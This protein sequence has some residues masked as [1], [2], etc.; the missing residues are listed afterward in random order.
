MA[1]NGK[2]WLEILILILLSPVLLLVTLIWLIFLIISYPFISLYE[3]WLKYQFWRRHGKFGRFVLFVYSDSPNW[4]DYIEANI[5]PCIKEH[6]VTLNW[7]KRR[8]WEQTNPF[9]AK[10]FY[11]WAGEEEFNPMA[12]I[13]PLSGKVKEV[14]FW[15]AFRDFKHGKDK[16]LKAAE[17]ILFGEVERC[18][19]SDVP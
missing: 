5:L 4:K 3:Q 7:S 15:Q 19:A 10:I 18:R 2:D 14:R 12:I 11:H 16:A 8:E 6:V 1:K 13:L 17:D 9:E